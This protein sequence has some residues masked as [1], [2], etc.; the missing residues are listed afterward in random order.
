M[1]PIAAIARRQ[2]RGVPEFEALQ[3]PQGNLG[4]LKLVAKA[5]GMADAATPHAQVLMDGGLEESFLTDLRTAATA[6]SDSR[7]G[8][9]GHLRTR[10]G[11]TKG[12]SEQE[13]N[14][15]TILKVL[16]S[17]VRQKLGANEQLLAEWN[18]AKQVRRP[19]SIPASLRRRRVR[20]AH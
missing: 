13:K 10:V 4:V 17:K 15:R 9:D 5:G 2:L 12:L 20:H 14:G 16:D 7:T 6:L 18:M 3:M 1:R 8:R 11:S 19:S